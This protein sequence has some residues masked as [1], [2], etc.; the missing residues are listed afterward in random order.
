M[1]MYLFSLNLSEILLKIA[2][3]KWLFKFWS[4]DYFRETE[5]R[6]FGRHF[7]MKRFLTVLFA[8]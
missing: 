1:Q 5:I 4:R 8:D 3:E 7:E 2:L 6:F